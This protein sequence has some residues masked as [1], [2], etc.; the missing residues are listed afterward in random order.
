MGGGKAG[1]GVRAGWLG[2]VET[3]GTIPTRLPFRGEARG[4]RDGVGGDEVG[5]GVGVGGW[6]T[7]WEKVAGAAGSCGRRWL[8]AEG[9]IEVCWLLARLG[10]G[11]RLSACRRW[12]L[13]E[14]RSC[15]L[16]VVG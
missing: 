6:G 9:S 5:I 13:V 11:C 8:G 4:N 7:L 14:A 3:V 10:A 12:M 16:A 2:Q 15:R 1:I